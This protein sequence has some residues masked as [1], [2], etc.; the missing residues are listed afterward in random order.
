MP[1]QSNSQEGN[2]GSSASL[3]KVQDFLSPR[4][5]CA[6]AAS[7]ARVVLPARQTHLKGL[8]RPCPEPICP[9]PYI[10]VCCRPPLVAPHALQLKCQWYQCGQIEG[11]FCCSRPSVMKTHMLELNVS[12]EHGIIVGRNYT[13]AYVLLQAISCKDACAGAE[14]Q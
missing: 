10:D 5:G 3:A 13:W 1:G 12:K 11:L 9:T 2:K 14:C 4:L 6:A 8:P 7:P